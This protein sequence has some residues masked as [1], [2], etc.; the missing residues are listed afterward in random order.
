MLVIL[1][2]RTTCGVSRMRSDSVTSKI[3]R[4]LHC[5]GNEIDRQPPLHANVSRRGDGL[6]PAG[7]I[8]AVQL[9]GAH[10][11]DHGSGALAGGAAHQRLLR[12]D[13]ATGAFDDRLKRHSH[14]EI[15]QVVALAMA[16]WM[17]TAD[18]AEERLQKTSSSTPIA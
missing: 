4:F 12:V 1:M 17:R 5:V 16:A 10:S 3:N 2:I 9:L 15:Q 18:F 11:G 6:D 13:R 8:E 14:F 7:L